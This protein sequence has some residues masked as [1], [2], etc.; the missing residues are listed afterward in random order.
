MVESI[1]DWC[2]NNYN[3][4]KVYI[5]CTSN[6]NSK[7]I[8]V[9]SCTLRCIKW[10]KIW[11]EFNHFFVLNHV[12]KWQ[13]EV[14]DILNGNFCICKRDL[15]SFSVHLIRL[16]F[17]LAIFRS[18]KSF[19][20]NQKTPTFHFH[21]SIIIT[22]KTSCSF[23]TFSFTHS[24]LVKYYLF[25]CIVHFFLCCGN[26]MWHAWLK[27]LVKRKTTHFMFALPLLCRFGC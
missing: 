14:I 15:S 5:K 16:I 1:F 26:Y 8:T 22:I 2:G 20:F 17:L 9:I 3:Q 19:T 7:R 18:H 12:P 25:I 6:A 23:Q 27:Y 13:E 21:K 11:L 10:L 4:Q 24:G